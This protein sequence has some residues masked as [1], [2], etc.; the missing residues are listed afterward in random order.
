MKSLYHSYYRFYKPHQKP[1]KILAI[2]DVHFAGQISADMRRAAN[3]AIKQAPSLIVISGDLVDNLDAINTDKERAAL[4]QWLSDLADLAPVCLC[5]GNHD[6]YRKSPN[7]KSA[8]NRKGYGYIIEKPTVLKNLAA[9][10]KNVHFLDN[11]SYEDGQNYVYGFTLPPDY[12]DC[13]KHPGTEDLSLFEAE[14]EKVA[15]SFEKLPKNKTKIIL[16]HSPAFLKEP[17]IRKHLENFDFIIAG[18]MHNGIVPPLLHEIWRG[19]SGITT[20]TKK[21]FRDHNTRLGL[22]DNQFIELGAITTVHKGS[23][24]FGWANSL[25]PTYVATIKI[26]HNIADERKPDVKNKYE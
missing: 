10:I 21:F 13:E 9:E 25:F 6:Y 23:K 19:H 7:F 22:Y 15:A 2:S 8:L 4:K 1:E 11:E 5:L 20:P 24:P 14:L 12:Y 26:S 17:S 16:I 3:F 18:H